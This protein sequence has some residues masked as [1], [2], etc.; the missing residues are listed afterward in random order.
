MEVTTLMSKKKSKEI[1]FKFEDINIDENGFRKLIWKR[2]KKLQNYNFMPFSQQLKHAKKKK[3]EKKI[4][5]DNILRKSKYSVE[6][7]T[8]N[9]VLELLFLKIGRIKK[10]LDINSKTLNRDLLADLDENTKEKIKKDRGKKSIKNYLYD[11]Y[12]LE[13]VEEIK[14][15]SGWHNCEG[16]FKYVI[17]GSDGELKY[18][19]N[20]EEEKQFYENSL[21]MLEIAHKQYT[22]P[23]FSYCI[24]ALLGSLYSEVKIK[25]DF[26]LAIKNKEADGII[27]LFTS[28]LDPHIDQVPPKVYKGISYYVHE[29]P[30]ILH[31]DEIK[32]GSI[33]GFKINNNIEI[34]TVNKDCVAIFTADRNNTKKINELKNLQ[35]NILPIVFT[36]KEIDKQTIL[37][38][39][40]EE[41]I[42]NAELYFDLDKEKNKIQ[43][44][45]RCFVT[46][47][48]S[49][50][51]NN[52]NFIDELKGSFNTCRDEVK[53]ESI[54]KGFPLTK[55]QSEI[56]GWLLSAYTMYL[57]FGKAS[58]FLSE[59]AYT[60]LRN[61]AIVYLNRVE[62]NSKYGSGTE[63]SGYESK[64]IAQKVVDIVY[65]L[66]RGRYLFKKEWSYIGDSDYATPSE[67]FECI[68]NNYA[69]NKYLGWISRSRTKRDIILCF[70]KSRFTSMINQIY[71]Q[72]NNKKE[73][74]FEDIDSVMEYLTDMN[75]INYETGYKRY[76]RKIK[77][78]SGKPKDTEMI[79]FRV[80]ILE[81]CTQNYF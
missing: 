25:P 77:S 62:V 46:W 13:E 24:L 40:F 22:L 51:S 18:K 27:E 34:G 80:S 74:L 57:D 65:L 78:P 61:E 72:L 53:S 32:D 38:L 63:K 36:E 17:L 70:E 73:N 39:G 33:K 7:M 26:I 15:R 42:H 3:N 8:N 59:G 10:I 19:L 20:I 14:A 23:L 2:D 67:T 1:S 81:K 11:L 49:E 44:V 4:K 5:D 48:E 45:A 9:G 54:Y 71:Q 37:S 47:L 12:V 55:R 58:N 68:K 43:H 64:I 52:E 31:S 41:G 79:A 16:K 6:I 35:Q 30:W 75:V 21:N 69:M 28:L 56:Y 50:I 76:K 66:N 60:K 29:R